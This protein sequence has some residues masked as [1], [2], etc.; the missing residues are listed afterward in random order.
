MQER[1]R[2][3]GIQLQLGGWNATEVSLLEHKLAIAVLESVKPR[4]K[5]QSQEI[6]AQGIVGQHQRGDIAKFQAADLDYI[7]PGRRRSDRSVGGLYLGD[8]CI[9]RRM[10][11]EPGRVARGQRNDRRASIDHKVDARPLM[12]P[13]TSKWPWALGAITT[14]RALH[15]RRRQWPTRAGALAVP[16]ARAQ[17]RRWKDTEELERRRQAQQR[18]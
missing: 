18:Q 10:N 4:Q 16:L 8:K 9:A 3:D 7:E 12:R 5:R 11:T 15:P 13:S 2:K 17:G 14:D 6:V 1:S